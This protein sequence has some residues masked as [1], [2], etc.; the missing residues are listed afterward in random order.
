MGNEQPKLLMGTFIKPMRGVRPVLVIC[1][2]S[3]LPQRRRCSSHY[4]V[5]AGPQQ[6]TCKEIAMECFDASSGPAATCAA[7]DR[8]SAQ[9]RRCSAMDLRMIRASNARDAQRALLCQRSRT[10]AGDPTGRKHMLMPRGFVTGCWQ[11]NMVAQPVKLDTM[12]KEHEGKSGKKSV[13]CCLPSLKDQ[14]LKP[15]IH[16][17][18]RGKHI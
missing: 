12:R 2:G 14:I 8:E 13:Q 17:S 16:P 4:V 10:P 1:W 15:P 18:L 5:A 11:A 9:H 3:M 6:R 7:N